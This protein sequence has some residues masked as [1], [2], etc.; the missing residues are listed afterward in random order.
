MGEITTFQ[1][2]I[3]FKQKVGLFG[4]RLLL[5]GANRATIV[6]QGENIML[7]VVAALIWRDGKFLI[8]RRPSNK[9]RA[10]LWEFVGGKREK[11]ETL[12]QALQRECREELDIEVRVGDV[13]CEVTHTYPDVTVHLTLFNAETSD[14]PKLLE[15]SDMRW[16]TPAEIDNYEFCPADEDILALLKKQG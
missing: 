11:G 3:Y 14:Q 2:S 9:K 15:H 13:F 10:L 8:C 12:P 4:A 16:I 6:K 5:F 1:R 7:E